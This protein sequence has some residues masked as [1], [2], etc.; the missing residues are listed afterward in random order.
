MGVPL[1]RAAEPP[2]ALEQRAQ[3]L[4]AAPPPATAALQIAAP[5]P[6]GLAA[7][8]ASAAPTTPLAAPPSRATTPTPRRAHVE[9]PALW[10]P[11]PARS[12]SLPVARE[13]AAAAISTRTPVEF[14]FLTFDSTPWSEVSVDG[15]PIGQTPVVHVKL[16]AGPHV[17][18]LVNREQ[19]LSTSYEVTIEAGKTSVRRVGLD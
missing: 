13:A 3:A 4:P 16:P 14:G 15:T 9:K 1:P 18:T 8:E 10:G 6:A 19:G 12:T 5:Q 11:E 2:R 17:L 7:P